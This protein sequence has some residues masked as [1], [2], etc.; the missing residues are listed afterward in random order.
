ML[1][2]YNTLTRRIDLFKP[3]EKGEVRFY[4]CGPTVYSHAHVGHMRTY[5]NNDLLRR[6][7]VYLGFK[8]THVMNITDVGH[9][10]G[11][12]DMGED[13][14]EVA[15]KKEK[16]TAWE[17][18]KE[19]EREFFD[20]MKVLNVLSP[21]VVCRATEYIQPMIKLVQELEKKGFTYR[22]GDGI[23][24]DTAKMPDYNALSKL[25]LD[26][27]KEGARVEANPEKRNP[28]DFAL[29]KFTP[30]GEVRQMEWPSPWA[31][32][33]FPG[34]HIECS[35]MSMQHLGEQI[36]IHAGGVDHID[37]HHTNERAQNWAATGHRVVNWWFH[38]EHL[39]IDG[40]K[41]SKSLAN[42]LTLEEIEAKGFEPLAVRYLF[43]TAHYRKRM[44]FTWE[45]LE[46]AQNAYRK[47]KG[48]VEELRGLTEATSV[49]AQGQRK[50]FQTALEDD[51]NIP[52]ALGAAWTM[53]KNPDLPDGEKKGLLLDFDQVLGLGLSEERK[54]A[55]PTDVGKLADER[56]WK[57]QA[58]DW[59]TSDQLRDK[60]AELGFEIE[61]TDNGY[62]LKKK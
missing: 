13:K 61:D 4:A 27:L 41:M 40:K 22:T 30:E 60:I 24:F 59:A 35:A 43:L 28:T 33:S 62:R 45:S 39:L 38:N 25:P 26:E 42:F 16:K 57:R 55:I 49:Q 15:A 31:E 8:V 58:G 14:L 11:D 50:I 20:V 10:R 17:I 7:L 54:T 18:A 53:L 47:L 52:Q 12:R 46:A 6:A 56:E 23:Y 2:L 37:I 1:Q 48:V 29:W 9:L 36:D 51:L 19:Y 3:I 5:I 34:W 44:N 32:K 21:D